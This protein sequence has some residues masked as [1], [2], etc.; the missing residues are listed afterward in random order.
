[1]PSGQYLFGISLGVSLVVVMIGVGLTSAGE[2]KKSD[3]E[4]AVMTQ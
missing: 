3:V 4:V 2:K 1:M